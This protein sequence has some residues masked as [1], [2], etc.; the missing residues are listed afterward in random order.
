MASKSYTNTIIAD[1]SEKIEAGALRHGIRLES[2]RELALQYKVSRGTIRSALQKLEKQNY[3]TIEPNS[4]TY[5]CY[6]TN[7][8]IMP[9]VIRTASPIELIDARIAMEPHI[10]RLATINSKSEQHDELNRLLELMDKSHNDSEAFSQHDAEFHSLLAGMTH[11]NLIIWFIQ[12]ANM[13]RIQEQWQNLRHNALN[14]ESIKAYNQQHR[15]I[16][17]AILNRDPEQAANNMRAHLYS[18]RSSLTG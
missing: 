17:A 10:C 5:V 14:P 16:V 13:V 18:A 3:V 6:E 2:E 1:L 12:L 9:N 8:E 4:G 11:N 15:E 7:L